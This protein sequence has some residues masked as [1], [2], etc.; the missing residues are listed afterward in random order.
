MFEPQ[1]QRPC[2]VQAEVDQEGDENSECDQKK[3]AASLHCVHQ[4]RVPLA[5]QRSARNLE[6]R[7]AGEDG[8]RSR[9]HDALENVHAEHSGDRQIFFAR[10]QQR[11]NW[12]SGAAQKKKA[13]KAHQRPRVNA[14]EVGLPQI[15]RETLPASGTNSVGYIDCR[16][17]E[18]EQRKIRVAPGAAQ[19]PPVKSLEGDRITKLIEE[20][21]EGDDRESED[22]ELAKRSA[23][24]WR[25]VAA[26][27]AECQE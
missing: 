11:A 3:D 23:H 19:Q 10:D 24:P 9:I 2:A 16:E 22:E 7:K 25:T 21:G 15:T 18:Q 4:R 12:L 5:C 27:L 13:R 26:T 17:R 6:Q 20:C 8:R 14:G 1:C